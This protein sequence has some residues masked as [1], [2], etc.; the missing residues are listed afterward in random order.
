MPPTLQK[1]YRLKAV[2]EIFG[3]RKSQIF[4]LVK[5]GKFPKPFTLSDGGRAVGWLE[6]DLIKLQAE[7]I[8][9]RD[10]GAAAE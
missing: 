5:A 3:Y 10:A 9:A 2:E 1:V 7:R 4:A 6:G 8:A